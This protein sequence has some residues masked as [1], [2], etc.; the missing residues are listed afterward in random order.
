MAPAFTAGCKDLDPPPPPPFSMFVRVEGDP[1][2]AVPG[3][4]VARSNK[5]LGTTGADGRAMLTVSGAEG[6]TFDVTV[7]C[8]EG[9][10]SPPRPV[11]VRLTRFADRTRIPEY[12]VACPPRL[13]RVVVAVR[14]ENGPHLPVLYLNRAVARTDASGAAHVALDVPPGAQFQLTL[15]T[16]ESPRLKPPSPSRPFTVGGRDDIL[17]FE[18]KFDVERPRAVPVPRPVI[19]RALN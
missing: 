14:A 11:G 12:A 5:V 9:F 17:L 7:S 15:D 13:R 4:V 6:E 19:P 3:A 8:P 10:T 16:T 2:Q 18:Q 1:G